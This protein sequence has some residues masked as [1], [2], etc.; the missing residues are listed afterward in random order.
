MPT[1]QAPIQNVNLINL[2]STRS[3]TNLNTIS[4]LNSSADALQIIN[5]DVEGTSIFLSQGESVTLSASTG[6]VLP[7]IELDSAGT[8]DCQVITT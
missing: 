8:I 5:A 7:T 4:I 2:T 1:Y 6:F 3:F